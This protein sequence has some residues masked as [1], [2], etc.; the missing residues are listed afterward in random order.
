[1]NNEQFTKIAIE[2]V[3]GAGKI[4][5]DNFEKVEHMSF[6]GRSDIV[7][8]IDLDSEK[9]I[10]DKISEH[11][12]GHS[13]HSEESGLDDHHS[14]YTWIMDPIDGTINYYHGNG[15]FRVGLCL[16]KDKQPII[17]A[18]YNPI[19]DRLYFAEKDKGATLN[20]KRIIVNE[21]FDIRNSVVMTHLS[22]KKD[23]RARTILALES[24]FNH[25]MHMR[26]F[27]SGLAAMSYIASGKFDVYF[28]VKTNPW[29]I[30]PGALLI[31]EAGGLVTDIEGKKITNESTSV[32][33]TNGKVHNECLKLLENI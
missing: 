30:L 14:E 11:F 25:T 18:I 19:A 28:N 9:F 26:M 4:V 22:S 20:G 16:L 27:G 29:D 3:M 24:I 13:I 33:A 7:T 6:K 17:T 10:I 1:M 23:A 5:R 31:E 15:P 32:L 21:N 12:P 2:C 8:Q